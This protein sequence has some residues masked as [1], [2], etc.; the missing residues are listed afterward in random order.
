MFSPEM[1]IIIAATF[2]AAGFVKGTIGLGLPTVTLA[3]LTL[4]LGLQP[5]LA[6]LVVPLVVANLVQAAQGGHFMA[7]FKRL[8]LFWLMAGISVAIGVHVLAAARSDVLVAILGV[9]LIL[10]SIISY[11]RFRTQPPRPETERAWS[12]VCGGLGGVMFGMT[13]NFIVPGILFLQALALPRNMMVQALGMTF[14]IISSVL[15]ITMTSKQMLDWHTAGLSALCLIPA[16]AGM[17]LGTRYRHRIS[18]EQFSRL[19]FAGLLVIG[20]SLL[21]GAVRNLMTG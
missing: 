9:I 4:P 19:F 5:T 1:L 12:A 8:W 6:L 13:G 15:A 21:F 14:C 11:T 16:F 18:E 3:L 7:L 10:N 20:V 17:W 2:V